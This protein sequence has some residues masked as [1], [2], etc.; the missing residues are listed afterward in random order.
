MKKNGKLRV[1][2]D[3]R[4]LNNAT[5]K[6]E[7]FM[8]IADMLIDSVARN[9]ILSFMDEDDVSKTTFCYP[10]ALGTYEWV[11]MPFGL[12]NTGATYQQAM[13][14][15]FHEYIGKSFVTMRKKGLKMNPLICAFGVSA[16]NFLGFVIHKKR[17]AI[18]KR[19]AD[20]IL[21]FSAPKSKKEVQSFLGKVNYLR[22]FT[23]NIS[24]RTRVFAPLVKLKNDSQFEWRDERQQAFDSIKAYLSKAP[25]MANVRP[26]KPLKLYIVASTNTIGCMLAQ[27]DENGHERV[28]YYLR[29]VLTDIETRYSPIERLCFVH[30]KWM[31]ALTE[32]NLQYVLVKA[33][34]GQVI[35]DFLVD[36]SNNL[37][38]QGANVIDIKVD[39]WKLYFDGSKHKDGA[40]VGIL[41]IS[42]EG[43]LSEFLF[44]LKYPCSNNMAEYEALILGLE[45]LIGKGALELSKEFKC[46]NEKLQEYLTTDWEL[47][48][49]F[50]KVSLVHI[51]RIYNEIANEN[52]KKISQYPSN[53]WYLGMK[54][55]LCQAMN[56]VLMV[57]EL[58]KKG[59]DGSLL[60][61][62]SQDDK[63]IA[64][65][66]VHKG[67]C[68]DHQAGMKMKWVLYR[69]HVYLPSMIKDCIK[70]AKACQECQKHGSIQQIP[71]YE[72]WALDLIRLI[73]P[74][75]SK[76]HKFILVGID[77][78]KK[79]VEAVPLI[80]VGQNEIIN[81]I[82]EH[83]IHRFRIPQTLSTDQGTMFTGQRVK[84]FAAS[85][86][87][88]WAYRNSPRGLTGASTYKLVY[89]HDVVLPL[90]IN[91]NTLRV[92]RQNDLLVDDYWN[93][94]FDELNE[95][96]SERILALE[97]MIRQK[98][99]G[100]KSYLAME[101]KSRVLGKWSHTREWPFQVIGLYSENAYRITDIE[102]GNIIKLINRKY[103]KQYYCLINED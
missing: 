59:I 38:D 19:K 31:L 45:I 20:A 83:I 71:A 67:I 89:G 68:G 87:V 75:S 52:F 84:N 8:P 82:E 47:L 102:S 94:I 77:Y 27:D 64:L 61:C 41:I 85:S 10:G 72:G 53:F 57:D 21:A 76:H 62:L 40:G 2:I 54:G 50:Q 26:H 5:P 95:L 79:W 39:Y 96:D 30:G 49:S 86:Q 28:I 43:I 16:G 17:I 51:P 15:I 34:K 58:Y 70:Y 36:N 7:Y 93:A 9:E 88:L 81:F 35:A 69:N 73:H 3:F 12:K 22:R 78:F 55:K 98:E 100:F 92:S 97:N 101:K 90:E 11:V 6:D 33:V 48:T 60:R 24:N 65:G 74:P 103:L 4:D 46:N 14:A 32:F 13:N 29:R 56:F 80:K 91:L 42:P 25:I 99:I 1:Y 37:N 23:L 18:D 63:D 66:E 44:E